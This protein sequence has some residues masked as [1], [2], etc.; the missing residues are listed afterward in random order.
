MFATIKARD[1][2][3]YFVPAI[4]FENR[5][6]RSTSLKHW[7]GGPARSVGRVGGDATFR[8]SELFRNWSLA[9]RGADDVYDF[10]KHDEFNLIPSCVSSALVASH[11][12]YD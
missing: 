2:P 11:S 9:P 5:D 7:N 6:P 10:T 12:L 4:V 3:N 1:P 8:A